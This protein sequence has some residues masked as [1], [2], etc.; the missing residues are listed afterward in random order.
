MQIKTELNDD[1]EIV[2]D[3]TGSEGAAFENTYST[4]KIVMLKP[5]ANEEVASVK[6]FGDWMLRIKFT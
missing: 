1:V 4:Q 5:L 6:L 3:I 2:I